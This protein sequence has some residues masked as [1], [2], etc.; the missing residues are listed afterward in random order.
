MAQGLGHLQDLIGELP[1]GTQD[2]CS[3]PPGLGLLPVLL[4]LPQLM[5]LGA[6]QPKSRTEQELQMH[7]EAVQCLGGA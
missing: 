4:L 1:G 7:R 6:F 3:G 5:H 2:Q